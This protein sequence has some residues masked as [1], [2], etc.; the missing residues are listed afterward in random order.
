MLWETLPVV[1]LVVCL[2]PLPQKTAP[3]KQP[4][5]KKTKQTN[6]KTP[7]KT[8]KQQQQQNSLTR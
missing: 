4:Y 1:S 5:F 6:K 2:L 3:E 8:A 7:Q